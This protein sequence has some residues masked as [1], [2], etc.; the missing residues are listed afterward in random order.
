MPPTL[1]HTPMTE[2]RHP[3]TSIAILAGGR[4]TRMQGVDKGLQLLQG[5][6]LVQRLLEQL[7]GQ[8]DDL[9]LNANRNQQH[10]QQ[11]SNSAR[12]IGD[13]WPDFR[14]PLAGMYSCLQ[15]AKHDYLLVI[16]C[17]LI[18]PPENLLANMHQALLDNNCLAAYAEINQQPLY[19]LCLLHKSGLDSLAKQLQ[20]QQYA[21]RHWLFNQL[22]CKVAFQ[23]HSNAPINLNTLALLQQADQ[24]LQAD[25][26]N[27][28]GAAGSNMTVNMDAS[29]DNCGVC[30]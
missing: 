14:G 30:Q 23:L 11:L 10:Y 27:Q 13:E 1:I 21:V 28:T 7:T 9:L 19:P 16:P 2:P 5:K 8:S 6:A 24:M 25:F 15:Q 4:A 18:A 17:D 12:I 22:A 29:Q 26:S 3:A 20:T